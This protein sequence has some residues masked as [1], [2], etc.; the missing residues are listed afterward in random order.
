MRIRRGRPGDL[1]TVLALERACFP[2]EVA[3]PAETVALILAEATALV[4][5]GGSIVGFVAGFARGGW[6]TVLTLEVLPE[7]RGRGVGRRLMVALEEE[8]ASQ[9][10]KAAL[11]EVSAENERAVALY[12]GLGYGK[13]GLLRGYY[14]PGRDA[15][16]M[17]RRLKPPDGGSGS[18]S[19]PEGR[20][21]G[22]AGP[23]SKPKNISTNRAI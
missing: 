20:R 22:R 8:L 15:L 18:F 5:E 21:S 6:G 1:P 19:P 7:G 13:A 14:G 3:F 23:S 11:L 16:L 4:A 9:G 17:T 12:A 10:A 2:P